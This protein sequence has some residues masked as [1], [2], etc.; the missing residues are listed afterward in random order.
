MDGG[1]GLAGFR[2]SGFNGG[3]AGLGVNLS[4]PFD[5]VRAKALKPKTPKALK[6]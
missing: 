2:L 1:A 5:V 6:P 3:C 4:G